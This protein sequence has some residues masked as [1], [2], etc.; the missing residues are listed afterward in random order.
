[1]LFASAQTLLLFFLKQ[2]SKTV[3]I[4]SQ[5]TRTPRVTRVQVQPGSNNVLMLSIGLTTMFLV[6]GFWY[7]LCCSVP[8]ICLAVSVSIHAQVNYQCE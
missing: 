1:M 4:T 2:A 3:V 8:A 5:P 6:C 7:P